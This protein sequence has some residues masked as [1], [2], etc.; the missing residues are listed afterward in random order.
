MSP[1]LITLRKVDIFEDLRQEHLQK[2][3]AVCRELV[4]QAGDVIVRE[5]TPSDELFIIAKGAVEIVITPAMMGA[6]GADSAPLTLAT[7]RQ[8]QTFGEVGLV[9]RGL[10]SAT[11]RA[12]AK[13]TRLLAI[14]RQDLIQLCESDYEMGYL[15]MRNIASDLAFKIRN[16]DLTVRE[17]LLWRP[18]GKK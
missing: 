11:A 12:A 17:Q 18:G 7:L 9:D 1:W 16:T 4:F 2:L 15:L 13:E 10:R 8:G 5:N 6:E 14:R 3:A